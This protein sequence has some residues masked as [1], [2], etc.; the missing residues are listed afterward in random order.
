MDRQSGISTTHLSSGVLLEEMRMNYFIVDAF[1]SKPFTGNPAAVV[2]LA[3][4]LAD[5]TLQ[6]IAGEFNLAETAFP[7]RLD[8]GRFEL[9]WFT[10]NREVVLCGHATLAAA[11]ALWESGAVANHE[12]IR[13]VTCSSGELACERGPQGWIRMDFPA[14]P[15]QSV[16]LPS[17][18]GRVLG[19][20]GPV[21]CVGTTPMNL[22]L[23]LPTAQQVRACKPDLAALASWHPV[24]VIVTAP[25]DEAGVDFVSRFFAPQVGVPEDPVT[26]SAHCSL[27]PYWAGET[28]RREFT[29]RQLSARGGELR[30]ELHGERVHL[31]GQAVTTM[32]GELVDASSWFCRT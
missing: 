15:P 8:D 7:R 12:P 30:L 22:T 23:R 27:V 31:M 4:P 20:P 11:H 13:F 28:G 29:A 32:R 14:T 2:P 3:V 16:P 26:G 19:V 10:P 17:D 6:A 18:A 9:R 25:G 5:Q 1:A 24:G 21:V